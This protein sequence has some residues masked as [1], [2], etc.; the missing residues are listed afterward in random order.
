MENA[1]IMTIPMPEHMVEKYQW[2]SRADL[3]KLRSAIPWNPQ[4]VDQWLDN[5]FETLLNKII[6]ENT[7]NPRQ[8]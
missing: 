5:N 8:L 1:Q 3:N 2:E 4:S 7:R 6:N